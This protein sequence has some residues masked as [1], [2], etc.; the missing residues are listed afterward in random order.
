MEKLLPHNVNANSAVRYF[1]LQEIPDTLTFWHLFVNIYRSFSG[2]FV[3][4]RFLR[5]AT[6]NVKMR[7]QM[8]H[9]E[10][11]GVHKVG[12]RDRKG[13]KARKYGICS[14]S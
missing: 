2:S 9:H 10:S 4:Y 7:N 8:L 13:W 14:H 11:D 12:R 5:K 1:A 6:T 3:D